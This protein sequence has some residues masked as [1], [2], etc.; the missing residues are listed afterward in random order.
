MFLY[1]IIFIVTIIVFKKL[2]KPLILYNNIKIQSIIPSYAVEFNIK[3]IDDIIINGWYIKSEKKNNIHILFS[4]DNKESICSNI[5]LFE[6]LTDYNIIT[7]DYRGY[8]KSSG[9]S[10]E[11]G[12]YIDIETVWNYMITEL[13]I[14]SNNIIIYGKEFGACPSTY[15]I[16]KLNGNFK[17][18]ILQ[19]PFYS[20]QY[21]IMDILPKILT[22]FTIFITEFKT[23]SYIK[24][25]TR[26]I[27]LL[28][29]SKNTSFIHSIKLFNCMP[30]CIYKYVEPINYNIIEFITNNNIN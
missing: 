2:I 21:V 4:H 19:N 15:L 5:E 11:K 29:N 18:S 17:S 14:S 7:Y 13:N 20:Y 10:T 30:N 22:I 8:G 27:L 28:Y 12:I 25:N 23:Y 9:Q 1:I 24:Y 3:T 6:K 26:P 16:S